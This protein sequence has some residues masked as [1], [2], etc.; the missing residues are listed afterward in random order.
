MDPIAELRVGPLRDADDALRAVTDL[1]QKINELV[2]AINELA[3]Q[4]RGDTA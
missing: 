2:R 3:D 4:L 1:E